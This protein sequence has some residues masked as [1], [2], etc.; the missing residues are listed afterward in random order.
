MPLAAPDEKFRSALSDVV[1]RFHAYG[2][3]DGDPQRA[4]KALMKRVPGYAQEFY[5][6]RF[7]LHLNLLLAT[8]QAVHNVP[9]HFQPENKY[10]Q[11]SDVDQESVLHKLR[12]LFPEQS[13]DFLTGYVGIVIYWYY[14]R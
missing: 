10:S 12:S 3:Y 14:L 2:Q 6:E 8:I 1:W 5:E 9:T 11:Y 13:D 4:I 7:T